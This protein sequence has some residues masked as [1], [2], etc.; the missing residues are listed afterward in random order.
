MKQS[1]E[2]YFIEKIKAIVSTAH[3]LLCPHFRGFVLKKIF[4]IKSK[5]GHGYLVLILHFE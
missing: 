2:S 5:A 3:I 1:V 4:L